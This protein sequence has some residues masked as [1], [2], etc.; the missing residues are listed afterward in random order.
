[1]AQDL[2]IGTIVRAHNKTGIYIGE[3]TQIR[4]E[5][6]V[7]RVL[8]VEKHP[9]QGDLHHPKKVDVPFFHERK[10]L[11]Y[12]EQTNIRKNMVKPFN[13]DIPDYDDS[14]KTAVEKMRTELMADDSDFAQRSL[15]C[16]E[17]LIRDYYHFE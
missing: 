8:A 12:R 13:G 14:L 7:V 11:S 6:Y 3:I 16:L 2:P 5:H 4:P 17:N 10:A 9:M 15:Q 1:M